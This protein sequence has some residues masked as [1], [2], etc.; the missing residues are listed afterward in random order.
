MKDEI[1]I[2]SSGRIP[3]VCLVSKVGPGELES[4]MRGLL[5]AEED[6][7]KPSHSWL[8]LAGVCLGLDSAVRKNKRQ[9]THLQQHCRGQ[10]RAGAR[11]PDTVSTWRRPIS[12]AAGCG[13]CSLKEQ[14]ELQE[15]PSSTSGDPVGSSKSQA[16]TLPLLPWSWY[17]KK[18]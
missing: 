9:L 10:V 15:G 1:S 18:M 3:P 13:S 2:A 17:P 8:C 16:S 7:M 11:T 4:T 12:A 14:E 6:P 5:E